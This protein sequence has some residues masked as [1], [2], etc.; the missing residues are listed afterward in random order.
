MPKKDAELPDFIQDIDDYKESINILCHGDP[1]SGKTRLWSRLPNAWL[2][3]IEDGAVAARAAGIKGLKVTRVTSWPDLV[4]AYE[5]ARDNP[6]AFDWIIVDSIT[7]AQALCI[8]HIMEQVVKAN[9][10]RDPLIPAQGDHFKWQLSM[11][12]LVMDFNELPTNVVW[13]ARSMIREDAEGDEIVV[14]LVEG[15]DYGISAWV[16]GEMGLLC[17]LAKAFKG[18]GESRKVVRKLYTNEHPMYWSKDRFDALP[19]VIEFTSDVG[20]A[21]K[22]VDL[23]SGTVEPDKPVKRT[24]PRKKG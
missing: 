19:H 7:K 16:C 24:T 13:I 22:I 15:K 23:I 1:G 4:E 9:S 20:V 11:K 10:S 5:W 18:K 17:Y 8:R 12:Q 14:P 3:A 6:D 21:K 2:L